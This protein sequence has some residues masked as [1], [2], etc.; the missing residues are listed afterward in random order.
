MDNVPI[1]QLS[2]RRGISRQGIYDLIKRVNEKGIKGVE[3]GQHVGRPASLTAEIAK[4]LKET[5]VQP[6]MNQGSRKSHW[7]GPLI[8]K[9]PREKHHTDIGR[10]QMI[11][12]LHAIDFSIQRGFKKYN[13]TDSEKQNVFINNL[14]K[15]P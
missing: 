4:D 14:I 9:Y 1:D 10:S 15:T 11:N 6:P 5:L 12:W 8:R 7:D 3:E 2:H 13:K